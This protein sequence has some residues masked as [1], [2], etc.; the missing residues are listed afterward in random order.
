MVWTILFG[1]CCFV[2]MVGCLVFGG[3]FQDEKYRTFSRCVLATTLIAAAVAL[4]LSCL[5]RAEIIV[6]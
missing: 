4:L 1:V 3:T 6:I 5:H 2:G